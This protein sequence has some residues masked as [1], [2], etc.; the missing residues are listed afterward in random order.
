MKQTINFALSLAPMGAQRTRSTGKFH[1]TPPKY[2]QWLKDFGQEFM[3]V[4]AGHRIA[5]KAPVYLDIIA[6][7]EI[8]KS[9]RK[10][11]NAIKSGE[12][13]ISTPDADNVTKAVADGLTQAGFWPDDAQAAWMSCRKVWGDV[14]GI[15]IQV[16]EL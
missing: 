14:A 2:R 1:Y 10:G 9:R 13:H 11:K 15:E 4:S 7:F 3:A 8:P 6:I 5:E 12:W 16:T